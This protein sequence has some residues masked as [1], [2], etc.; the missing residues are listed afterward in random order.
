MIG[1]H[2]RAATVFPY[3]F[4]YGATTGQIYTINTANAVASPVGTPFSTALNAFASA[5]GFGF[6]PVADRIRIDRS[7][8]ENLRVNS[9]TGAL[10]AVDSNLRTFSDIARI[11]YDR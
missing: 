6:D 5:F 2:I 11:A 8:E 9:N 3:S 7:S 4:L 1:M 10:I